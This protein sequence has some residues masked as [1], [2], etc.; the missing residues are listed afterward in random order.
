MLL[1]VSALPLQR[2]LLL[3]LLA[4][5]N[6]VAATQA[7]AY[8]RYFDRCYVRYCL[9]FL[10]ILQLGL[11]LLSFIRHLHF[12]VSCSSLLFP[13]LLLSRQVINA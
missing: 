10:L 6:A 8:V 3:L 2:L 13:A 11:L 4:A 5:V 12:G 9:V 7:V 1:M